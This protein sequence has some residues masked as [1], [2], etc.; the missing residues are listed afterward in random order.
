MHLPHTSNSMEIS[1]NKQT[2]QQ[3]EI[4]LQ[5]LFQNS[6]CNHKRQQP[7]QQQTTLPKSGNAMSMMSFDSTQNVPTR[8]TRTHQQFTSPNTI[9]QRR[10]ENNSTLP[11]LDTL[12]QR[13]HDKTISVKTYGRPTHTNQY[14]TYTS[15]N[16]TSAK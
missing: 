11:F 5:P 7:S 15:H 6:I 3:W 1:T 16:P 13:N 4:Q 8:T 14:L 12:V 2:E 9:H 10:K